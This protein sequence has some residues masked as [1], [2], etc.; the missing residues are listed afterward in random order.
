MRKEMGNNK[1]AVIAYAGSSL[2]CCSFAIHIWLAQR[3]HQSHLASRARLSQTTIIYYLHTRASVNLIPEILRDSM[4]TSKLI[5]PENSYL[6]AAG[7][8][9]TV[10]SSDYR[11]T[12]T[13]KDLSKGQSLCRADA[14]ETI[15]LNHDIVGFAMYLAIGTK[16]SWVVRVR[17]V[18]NVQRARTVVERGV[19]ELS[20]AVWGRSEEAKE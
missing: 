5:T 6:L 16:D 13:T 12:Q 1:I 11:N 14:N 3:R 10:P 9:C 7:L 17:K 8:R 20:S 2:P 4:A 15:G 18:D 19:A